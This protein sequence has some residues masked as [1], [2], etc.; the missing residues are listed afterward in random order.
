MNA[1]EI[2]NFIPCSAAKK[3]TPTLRKRRTDLHK[4]ARNR[5]CDV[6]LLIAAGRN[7]ALL[8][9]KGVI[10]ELRRLNAL[11]KNP[12]PESEL[13]NLDIISQEEFDTGRISIGNDDAIIQILHITD[14]ELEELSITSAAQKLDRQRQKDRERKQGDLQTRIQALKADGLTRE[15]IA[16]KLHLTTRQVK[17]LI[18]KTNLNIDIGIPKSEQGLKCLK[19]TR[20]KLSKLKELLTKQRVNYPENDLPEDE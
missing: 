10:G 19:R 16:S 9:P 12:L 3:L 6:N 8:T 14:A 15:E 17:R 13:D 18:Q 2:V 1:S 4:L 5:L 7:Q 20:E 11:F